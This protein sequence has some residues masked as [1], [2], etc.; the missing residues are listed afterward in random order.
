MPPKAR[1]YLIGFMGSGKSTAGR[2]LATAMNWDFIDLDRKIEEMAGKRIPEIFSTDGEEKF[3]ELEA[4]ALRTLPEGQNIIIS[5]GGG[6]PCH[7]SN[8]EYMLLTGLAV[9]I[10]LSPAQLSSRLLNSSAD[11]PLLKNIP[12]ENLK[13]FI[14]RKLKEREHW[15]QMANLTIEG[16]DL[17]ISVLSE[18]LKPLLAY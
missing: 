8:M 1:I 5:T 11:R 7:G 4:V 2:K 16:I 9:Y 18:K 14:E 6:A 12:D 17:E 3:R 15:Y 10:K 13:E